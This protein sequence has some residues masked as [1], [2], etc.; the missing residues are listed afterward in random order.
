MDF[1]P[2]KGIIIL[3][4][5]IIYAGIAIGQ[6]YAN[7]KHLWGWTP[8]KNFTLAANTLNGIVSLLLSLLM[9]GIIL[10]THFIYWIT[11][12][13]AFVISLGLFF[14]YTYNGNQSLA[15]WIGMIGFLKT[16]LI[17]IYDF[18]RKYYANFQPRE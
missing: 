5:A 8:P 6:Y 7:N 9:D 10:K 2:K 13:I 17:A 1:S 3:G 15:W 12:G 4:L 16:I 14:P 18:R 11:H